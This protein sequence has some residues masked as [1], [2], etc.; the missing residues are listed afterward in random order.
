MSFWRSK[1][2]AP[3]YFHFFLLFSYKAITNCFETERERVSGN[4]QV[5]KMIPEVA[6]LA[7]AWTNSIII[8]VSKLLVVKKKCGDRS[9]P[10][11]FGIGS[12][13]FLADGTQSFA[14]I[15]SMILEFYVRGRAT[16]KY[17]LLFSFCRTS[18]CYL[19]FC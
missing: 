19:Q 8:I 7:K 2:T 11:P 1:Q 9:I 13:L 17:I 16:L 3:K 6:W 12:M 18:K 10:S 5:F 14:T 4:A 15:T